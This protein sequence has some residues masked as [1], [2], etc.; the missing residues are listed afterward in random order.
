MEPITER[1][2]V[3]HSK[4]VT[5]VIFNDQNILNAQRVKELEEETMAV[6]ERGRRQNMV[7]DFCN[8]RHLTSAF[9][10]LIVKIHQ[11]IR[12]QGGYLKMQNVDP[13]IRKL[14][15]ITGLCKVIEIE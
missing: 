4:D 1:L 3:H 6:V 12:K 15:E 14:F 2:F 5:L 13:S 8:V 10:G 9:M 7:L 11:R